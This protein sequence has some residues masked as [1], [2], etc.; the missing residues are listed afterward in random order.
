MENNSRTGP[1]R[2]SVL[3]EFLVWHE[4]QS[5]FEFVQSHESEFCRSQVVPSGTHGPDVVDMSHRRSRVLFDAGPYHDLMAQRIVY[6]FSHIQ[7][8][9]DLPPFGIRQIEV[10]ITASNDGDFFRTHNDSEDA[11]LPSREITFVCFLHHEPKPFTGGELRIYDW[12]WNGNKRL[13]A[14]TF[15]SIVPQQN[16]IVFFPSAFPHEVRPI[17][18]PSRAFED[19]RLTLNG[20][21]HK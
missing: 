1:A 17:Q 3:E 9:L 18:C 4:I 11:Y 14:K 5:F 13:P 15:A 10:Q 20:W 7:R 6:Y 8:A 12:Y 16:Q 19:S 21:L 2:Y